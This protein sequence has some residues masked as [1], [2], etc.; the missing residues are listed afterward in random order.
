MLGSLA[1]GFTVKERIQGVDP[2]N[3][4]VFC[5]VLAGFIILAAKAARVQGWP[6]RDFLIGRVV[7]RSVSEVEAVTWINLQLLLSILLW[8]EPVMMLDKRWPFNTVFEGRSPDDGFA[9]DIPLGTAAMNDGGC[10]FVK[11]QSN[12]GPALVCVRANHGKAFNSIEPRGFSDRGGEV[13]C[14]N[15]DATWNWG[16]G[17]E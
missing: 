16:R 1:I 5:C 4:S 3:I 15:L 2:F 8:L 17:S 12:I 6:W 11:V 9:I 10:F 7:G 13:K 14:A